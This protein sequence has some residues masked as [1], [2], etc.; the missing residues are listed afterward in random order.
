MIVVGDQNLLNKYDLKSNNA[1]LAEEK[2]MPLYEE[3]MTNKNIEYTAGG[4]GQNSLRVAQVF[5]IVNCNKKT[6]CVI[7]IFYLFQWIVK[8]PNVAVFFG[9][10]GRD[11]YSEILKF[12]ANEEGVD[13]K[14]Q[15]STEKPTG[16]NL[17]THLAFTYK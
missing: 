4:S 5:S 3:L 9:A 8:Q 15:Y 10:V 7:N 11:K 14:Y 2:H 16:I 17:V 1:I 12:K 13:V 6:F